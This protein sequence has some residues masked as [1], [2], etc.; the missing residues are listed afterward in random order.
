M[1][2]GGRIPVCGWISAYNEE[3][4]LPP[5]EKFNADKDKHK[6]ALVRFF[7]QSEFAKPE[8]LKEHRE[9]T[10]AWIL[11]GTLKVKED[12][13]EGLES[14]P[15]YFCGMLKGENFGKA[16]ISE[17]CVLHVVLGEGDATLG[18]YERERG[19]SKNADYVKTKIMSY[20]RAWESGS[21]LEKDVFSKTIGS[22]GTVTSDTW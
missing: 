12:V 1:N 17:L 16:T 4:V 7:I 6:L 22:S 3:N 5:P 14:A 21:P 2:E 13:R 8:I 20:C 10:E 15:A 11:N 18:D 19:N 9:K